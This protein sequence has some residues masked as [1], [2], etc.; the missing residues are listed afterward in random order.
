MPFTVSPSSYK[1]GDYLY[2]GISSFGS[3]LGNA[4]EDWR[5]RQSSVD[6]FDGT[7]ELMRGM[8]TTN[9]KGEPVPVMNDET[10]N[11]YK[12]IARQHKAAIGGEL[13]GAFRLGHALAKDRQYPVTFNGQTIM[14]SPGTAANV[15]LSREQQ[16]AREAGK[17]DV[18]IPGTDQKV[19]VSGATAVSAGEAAER[20]RLAQ[21]PKGLTLKDKIIQARQARE[22]QRK[23]AQ[24]RPEYKFEQKYAVPPREAI[25]GIGSDLYELR[26]KSGKVI[27][28]KWSAGTPYEKT[29]GI[30]DPSK[31][32][33]SYWHAPGDVYRGREITASQSKQGL[34]GRQSVSQKVFRPDP[35]GEILNIKGQKIPLSEV[36]AMHNRAESLYKQ[37]AEAILKAP[38]R[39]GITPDGKR[40]PSREEV[41]AKIIGDLE[42]RGFDAMGINKYLPQQ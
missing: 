16:A 32:P 12:S 4:I 29:E 39:P 1:G 7:L 38:V 40:I 42:E 31:S 3:N 30:V 35:S 26:D 33:G 25:T 36:E 23:I 2:G 37:A 18:T 19:K 34:A 41:Q 8:Q 15:A 11:Y 21:E 22:E 13:I 24:E 17:V 27:G 10:Y 14:A 20:R 28:R 5:K 6:Q 9:E